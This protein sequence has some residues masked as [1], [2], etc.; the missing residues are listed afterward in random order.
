MK[1]TKGEWL[2]SENYERIVSS[3]F[4][5]DM[6]KRTYGEW[7]WGCYNDFICL[8]DDG[9]RFR[10]VDKKEREANARLISAA[11]IMYEILKDLEDRSP[12]VCP[13]C[14][15]EYHPQ[16]NHASDCALVAVL[17]FIEGEQ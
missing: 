11:P 4:T 14:K 12:Y 1:H 13:T 15:Y 6:E 10:Y 16:G 5:N 3:D 7:G 17:R 8:L 9:E 2:I